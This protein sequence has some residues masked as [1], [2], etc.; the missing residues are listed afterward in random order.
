MILSGCLPTTANS[1]LRDQL[2]LE[3]LVLQLLLHGGNERLMGKLLCRSV[4][5]EQRERLV[6]VM[7]EPPPKRLKLVGVVLE[8]G[9]LLFGE[10]SSFKS[11]KARHGDPGRLADKGR[12]L[13]D[14]GENRWQDLNS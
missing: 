5:D 9:P 12:T 4:V 6:G 1:P 3:V 13:G 14:V 7:L 11:S 2:V 8:F 10:L